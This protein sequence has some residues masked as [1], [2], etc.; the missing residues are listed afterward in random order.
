MNVLVVNKYHHM[1]TN[2][3]IYIGRPSILGNPFSHLESYDKTVVRVA[4][5]DEAIDRYEEYAEELMSFDNEYSREINRLRELHKKKDLCLVCFCKSPGKEVR[6][7]GDIIK[8]LI[9]T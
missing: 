8:K 2:G 1:E 9:E 4:T 7:H 6:C 3:D 5:R